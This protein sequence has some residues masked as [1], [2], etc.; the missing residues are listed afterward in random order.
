MSSFF[1]HIVFTC[2]KATSLV[3]FLTEADAMFEL[4]LENGLQG[5]GSVS[6]KPANS[7]KLQEN[8]ELLHGRM[9]V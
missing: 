9:R 3:L 2:C 4:F 1:I 5:R 7:Q 6:F 8:Y